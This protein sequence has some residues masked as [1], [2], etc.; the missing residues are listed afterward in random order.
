MKAQN[1]PETIV[2]LK[3]GPH[4]IDEK[5]IRSVSRK[6]KSTVISLVRGADITVDI[7]YDKVQALVSAKKK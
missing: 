7:A 2:W 3:I 4:F 6:G 1:D 5:N